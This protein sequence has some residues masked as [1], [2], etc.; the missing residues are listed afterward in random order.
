MN[1]FPCPACVRHVR[2]DEA[3][4]P[5][6]SASLADVE[7]PV[8]RR[9]PGVRLSRAARFAFGVGTLS[10]AC[11]TGGQNGEVQDASSSDVE[12]DVQAVS[13]DAS[14]YGSVAAIDAGADAFEAAAREG[15]AKG[16]APVDAAE[17]EA[18]SASDARADAPIFA[19]GSRGE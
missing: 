7:R 10:V 17:G 15:G 18:G 14:F 13:Y 4:C 9:G 12:H 2:V 5:F 19:D 3:V 16:D 6:C 8:A 11:G 1:L